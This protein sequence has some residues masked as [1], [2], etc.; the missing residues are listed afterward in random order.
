MRLGSSETNIFFI[1]PTIIK[2]VWNEEEKTFF[3]KRIFF[4]KKKKHG[5]VVGPF[6][7]TDL[8]IFIH[9]LVL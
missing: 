3:C 6:R 2:S 8:L 4:G 1:G 5:G 7:R 9:N